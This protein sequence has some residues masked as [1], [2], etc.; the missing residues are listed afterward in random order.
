MRGLAIAMALMLT[1]ACDGGGDDGGGDDAPGDG[2]CVYGNARYD[3]GDVFPADDGCNTCACTQGE[4]MC[5]LVSCPECRALYECGV[6]PPC[7]DDC[8]G[9]GEY[10]VNGACR[11]GDGPA[12]GDGD[13]CVAPGP[14]S[15]GVVCCGASAP[16]P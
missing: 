4:V 10:C 3:D 9:R 6:G 5:T 14:Y 11:C 16:C 13:T 8:C 7:G 15:C 1:P 12:C 2:D